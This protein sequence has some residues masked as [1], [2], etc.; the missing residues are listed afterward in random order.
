[1]KLTTVLSILLAIG[2]IAHASILNNPSVLFT[3]TAGTITV[4]DNTG[5]C[6]V[7]SCG[8]LAGPSG[9]HT[10]PVAFAFASFYNVVDFTVADRLDWDTDLFN[11]VSIGITSFFSSGT[12]FSCS[13]A[14]WNCIGPSD[15]SVQLVFY[16]PW[17]SASNQ[18]V[19]VDSIGFTD[20]VY[21]HEVPEPCSFGVMLLVGVVVGGRK[22]KGRNLRTARQSA[23]VAVHL[24]DASMLLETWGRV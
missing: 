19:T 4:T 16:V 20:P 24:E 7:P 13:T 15:T 10:T 6:V 17:Y 21:P 2:G 5:R 8:L 12:K 23:V 3:D 1:M 11:R 18:L 22:L 9:T 14:G